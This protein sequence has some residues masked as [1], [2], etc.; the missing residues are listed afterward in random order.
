MHVENPRYQNSLHDL[1]FKAAEQKGLK[2]NSDFN[3]WSH[4][5]ASLLSW[6]AKAR[7][8]FAP[9]ASPLHSCTLLSCKGNPTSNH[10]SACG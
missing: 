9:M 5:Q 8:G 2:A 7:M 6:C 10:P 4:P 1:F 3:D